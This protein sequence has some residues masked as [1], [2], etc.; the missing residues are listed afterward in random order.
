[1]ETLQDLS[2]RI[3]SALLK[4]LLLY[5]GLCFIWIFLMGSIRPPKITIL[6]YGIGMIRFI[7]D[8]SH[9]IS[10][11]VT[12]SIG[13]GFRKLMIHWGIKSTFDLIYFWLALLIR[14]G[15]IIGFTMFT[16]KMVI[17]GSSNAQRY[18]QNIFWI[19]LGIV[20]LSLGIYSAPRIAG[21]FHITRVRASSMPWVEFRLVY[22]LLDA[23]LR[24]ILGIYLV[25]LICLIP[26]QSPESK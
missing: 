5:F 16:S 21:T 14:I 23:F 22:V 8:F 4:F 6:N 1:M 11:P 25:S 17:H 7:F 15:L 18:H 12:H 2:H 13:R 3:L 10:G 26:H 24:F 9:S 19:L 20:F